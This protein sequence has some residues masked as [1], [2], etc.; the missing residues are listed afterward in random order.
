VSVVDQGLYFGN[1]LEDMAP[2][3]QVSPDQ[4]PLCGAVG[5][6]EAAGPAALVG[7]R[8]PYDGIRLAH[9]ARSTAAGGMCSICGLLH[10]V[11]R[12][13]QDDDGDALAAAIAICCGVKCAAPP[14]RRQ[15]L[16]RFRG[17]CK[18]G[19]VLLRS[20]QFVMM[21]HADEHGRCVTCS[22]QMAFVVPLSSMTLLP[23]ATD[24][25]ASPSARPYK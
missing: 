15:S 13:L 3:A 20:R 2:Q 23:A 11:P 21:M 1:R 18:G 17:S 24:T 16:H 6:C 10:G 9:V 14:D 8:T 5:R 4:R 19:D 7:Y 25:P 22:W 12:W